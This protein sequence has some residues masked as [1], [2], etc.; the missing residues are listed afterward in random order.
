MMVENLNV[1]LVGPPV[2]IGSGFGRIA[3]R[4]R[5][6]VCGIGFLVHFSSLAFGM[7][8]VQL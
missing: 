5:T 7:T 8:I 4:D 2:A 1:E 6:F 3:M